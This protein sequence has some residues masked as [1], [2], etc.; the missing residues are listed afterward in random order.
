MKIQ[1]FQ[2]IN[3]QWKIHLHAD[4]F[5]RMQCQLVLAFGEPS[6]I[7]DQSVFNH[8]ERSYPEAHIILSAGNGDFIHNNAL[9]NTV[10]VTAIQ[11]D[12]TLIRCT[13]THIKKHNNSYDAGNYLMQQLK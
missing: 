2:Y 11:L 6:L 3:K 7:T 10:F 13:Q 8:L 1:Q 4:D 9:N 12:H 5:D